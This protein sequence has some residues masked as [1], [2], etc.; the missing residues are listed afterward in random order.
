MLCGELEASKL[1][2]DIGD[3]L[4]EC[5][6]TIVFSLKL[7]FKN[8]TIILHNILDIYWKQTNLWLL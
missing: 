7:K 2:A 4:C 5:L 3:Y 1:K 6:E 8:C